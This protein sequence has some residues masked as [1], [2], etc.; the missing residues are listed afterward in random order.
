[1]S[2]HG[3]NSPSSCDPKSSGQSLRQSHLEIVSLLQ[4]F[5]RIDTGRVEV[6]GSMWLLLLFEYSEFGTMSEML[7]A[8]YADACGVKSCEISQK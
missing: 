1:M 5:M 6:C 8:M 3:R 7:S 4:Y 2:K